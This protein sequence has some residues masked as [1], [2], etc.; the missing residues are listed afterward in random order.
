MRQ[1][2]VAANTGAASKRA[3][4]RK[5]NGQI[6]RSNPRPQTLWR[7]GFF[8]RIGGFGW[9]ADRLSEVCLGRGYR[10][11]QTDQ[12]E[13]IAYFCMANIKTTNRATIIKPR[14]TMAA[15]DFPVA[16]DR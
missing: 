4:G 16:D 15:I 7:G 12:F 9:C 10:G 6:V 13:E 2:R 14:I 11:L 1:T 5:R 3:T 8:L